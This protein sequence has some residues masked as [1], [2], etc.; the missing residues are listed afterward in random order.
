[1]TVKDLQYWGSEITSSL[2]DNFKVF[3]LRNDL[4]TMF[5]YGDLA[6]FFL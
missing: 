5:Q 4:R 3:E 1:M 2:S 6:F